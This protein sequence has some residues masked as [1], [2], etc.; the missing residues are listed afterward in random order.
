MTSY[1][2]C[3]YFVCPDG[4]KLLSSCK[5]FVSHEDK[6]SKQTYFLDAGDLYVRRST[7]IPQESLVII[8]TDDPHEV[9]RENY[10]WTSFGVKGDEKPRTR[11]IKNLDSEHIRQIIETQKHLPKEYIQ[12]FEN[13]LTYRGQ[14]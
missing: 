7:N 14:L 8:H 13:E 5:R 3:A 6:K 4:H 10:M 9:V 2:I 11:P 12:V 1:I